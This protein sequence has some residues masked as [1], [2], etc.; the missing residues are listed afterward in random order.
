MAL[1]IA[2][3]TIG[4][5]SV[6]TG[7]AAISLTLSARRRMGNPELLGYLKYVLGVMIS[8]MLFSSWHTARNLFGLKEIY[9][10]V[11]ELPEYALVIL[12]CV[13][14]LL[15]ARSILRMSREYGFREQGT[16]REKE[17]EM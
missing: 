10:P 3:G 17:G 12:T 9:G 7:I 1:D 11:I 13:L 16:K 6:I 14:L 8:L 4:I 5:A 15:G 2:T